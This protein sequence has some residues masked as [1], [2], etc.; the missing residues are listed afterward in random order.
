MSDT[1]VLKL[2]EIVKQKEEALG[3]EPKAKYKTNL[4]FKGLNILTMQLEGVV[5]CLA[6]VLYEQEEFEQASK[7]IGCDFS[8]DYRDLIDDLVLRGKILHYKERKKELDVLKKQL[9]SLRSEDLRRNDEL[10][11]LEKLLK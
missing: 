9:D 4:K 7:L 3:V 6:E 5:K 8:L 10:D 11:D 2:R 1:R